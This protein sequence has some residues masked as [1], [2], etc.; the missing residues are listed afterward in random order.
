MPGYQ[1]MAIRNATKRT[2]LA[3]RAALAITQAQKNQ[4]LL[5]H[6]SLEPGDG[7]WIK[8]TNAVHTFFMK[9]PIDLVYLSKDKKVV[10]T[11]HAV[12]A[13][14]LSMALGAA[15]IL[16]LPAGVIRE[17]NTEPGDQ[18]EFVSLEGQTA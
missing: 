4:G 5:K 10:K 14:R 18:L 11:R 15:S 9:F 2:Q 13:W 3:D 1:R 16:E 17:T 6:I 7:L 12:P 8:G